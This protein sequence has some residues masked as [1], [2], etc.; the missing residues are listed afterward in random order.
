MLSESIVAATLPPASW[1]NLRRL[2]SR[3]RITARIT[4]GARAPPCFERPPPA[5]ADPVT[6]AIVGPRHDCVHAAHDVLTSRSHHGYGLA[7]E[8]VALKPNPRHTY[9]FV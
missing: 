8:A 3:I 7:A 1:R 5:P 4:G 9:R 2:T 6:R